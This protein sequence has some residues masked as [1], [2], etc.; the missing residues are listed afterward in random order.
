MLEGYKESGISEDGGVIFLENGA[1]KTKIRI[2]K[3]G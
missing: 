2:L 1:L 3:I